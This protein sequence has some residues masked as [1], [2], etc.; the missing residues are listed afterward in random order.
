MAK[1]V[2]YVVG[3]TRKAISKSSV[4]EQ[5]ILGHWDGILRCFETTWRSFEKKEHVNE[6]VLEKQRVKDL[7]GLGYTLGC[8]LETICTNETLGPRYFEKVDRMRIPIRLWLVIMAET[9][10][11]RCF[12]QVQRAMCAAESVSGQTSTFSKLL[13]EESGDN[14]GRLASYCVSELKYGESHE[15]THILDS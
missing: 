3:Q 8:F 9:K 14:V 2:V 10:S 13:L 1:Q 7:L 5:L 4:L 6:M 15:P 11:G 12:A